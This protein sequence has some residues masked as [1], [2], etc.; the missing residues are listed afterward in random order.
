MQLMHGVYR[1][2]VRERTAISGGPVP[3]L[4]AADACSLHFYCTGSKNRTGLAAAIVLL[5]PGVP[6]PVIEADF[7]RSNDHWRPSRSDAG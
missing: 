5:A 4:L 7:L 6:Q 2:F 3:E 1:R